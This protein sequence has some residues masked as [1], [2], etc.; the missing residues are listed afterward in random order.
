MTDDLGVVVP[1]DM[2]TK[3]SYSSSVIEMSA[4]VRKL[5]APPAVVWASLANPHEAGA[6]PWLNLLAREIE[7]EVLEARETDRVV[8]SSLWPSRP[9]D[10]VIFDV[11]PQG[12]RR[13]CDSRC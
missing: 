13:C 5:P 12:P 8:W 7:P 2:R 9:K 4:K 1:F 10:R 3:S 11:S 6:R